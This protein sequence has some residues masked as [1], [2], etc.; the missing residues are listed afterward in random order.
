MMSTFQW[1]GKTLHLKYPQIFKGTFLFENDKFPARVPVDE[2]FN[3]PQYTLLPILPEALPAFPGA[4]LFLFINEMKFRELFSDM[5]RKKDLRIVRCTV[6]DDGAIEPRAIICQVEE[7]RNLVT[8]EA[9]Y[10]VKADR[11]VRIEK[12]IQRPGSS[13]LLGYVV[14]DEPNY[15]AVSTE[16]CYSLFDKLKYFLRLCRLYKS[17]LSRSYMTSPDDLNS[18]T[19]AVE[20]I[21]LSREI[22]RTQP[23]SWL[24]TPP[25][26]LAS[27]QDE[28]I[29]AV[30]NF[31]FYPS[32]VFEIFEGGSPKLITCS[33]ERLQSA[34][35]SPMAVRTQIILELLEA[36]I[37]KQRWLI[38]T[39]PVEKSEIEYS[40]RKILLSGMGEGEYR[41][42]AADL[43]PP[44]S[45]EEMSL[46]Q[47]Q[48]VDGE[49]MDP[50]IESAKSKGYWGEE[51]GDNPS[52]YPEDN[53]ADEGFLDD[54]D[55]N[56]M[57]LY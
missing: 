33:L 4:R 57:Q 37:E 27:C 32:S 10:I 18:A 5:Y 56:I 53:L 29:S 23:S 25:E 7:N 44:D 13:Y 39:S 41:D 42:Q 43:K 17:I 31:L 35:E 22:L 8:G 21:Y 38:E 11:R 47:V 52:G 34:F 26:T 15:D 40:I 9:M 20:K 6:T 49:L 1:R 36:A 28:F 12:V 55:E 19:A 45:W 24:E 46:S 2:Q 54:G 3:A 48:I 16:V 30:T 50:T 14:D 51:V